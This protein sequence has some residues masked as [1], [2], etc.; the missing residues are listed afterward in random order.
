MGVIERLDLFSG[1]L[2]RKCLYCR[3]GYPVVFGMSEWLEAFVCGAN[4]IDGL[5]SK[6]ATIRLTEYSGDKP[7]VP[8]APLVGAWD[9]CD[10]FAPVAFRPSKPGEYINSR[11]FVLLD[12]T[13][14]FD[15]M[16]KDR[17]DWK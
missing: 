17:S 7:D 16:P 3:Y 1:S 5:K 4:I 8:Y 11:K 12:K 13:G 14:I 9:A 10:R 2:P 6:K 15:E